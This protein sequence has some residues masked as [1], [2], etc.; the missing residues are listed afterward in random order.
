M[1]F[2]DLENAYDLCPLGRLVGVTVEVLC[3][4]AITVSHPVLI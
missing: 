4:G 2:V 1:C 3:T